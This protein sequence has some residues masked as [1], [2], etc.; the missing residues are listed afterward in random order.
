MIMFNRDYEL[1]R[2]GKPKFQIGQLVR[3]KRYH[4]RGVVVAMDPQCMAD[5]D[6]YNSNQ[7]QPDRDQPWYHVFVD[8]SGSVTYPGETSLE[9]DPSCEPIEHPMIELFFEKFDGQR[10]IR[11]DRPWPE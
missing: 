1:E 3:H 10:Y 8:A 5:D 4:Y 7:T 11:N 9:A 2:E 6:W